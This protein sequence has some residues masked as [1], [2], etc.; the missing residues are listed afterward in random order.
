MPEDALSETVQK[1]NSFVDAGKDAEF[2]KPRM[3]SRAKSRLRLST[4]RG[5]SLVHDTCGGLAVN[6]RS[7]V[8]DVYGNVI[9]GLYAGGEAA[10]GLEFVG[11]NR[12][13]ILGRIAGENA[14]AESAVL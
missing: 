1:Y 8:L 13:I 5:S 3:S 11:M 9:P 2:D 6:P 4:P 12:G 14:A 10:G 7:Q